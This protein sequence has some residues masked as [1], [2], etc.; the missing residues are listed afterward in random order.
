M[1][2]ARWLSLYIC[3]NRI[4]NRIHHKKTSKNNN[5]KTE[6]S[7]KT[8]FHPKS[9]IFIE[10]GPINIIPSSFCLGLMPLERKQG[11]IDKKEFGQ[12]LTSAFSI[13]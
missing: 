8:D 12:C 1:L 3:Q 10:T 6:I 11:K 5:K 7:G 13:R 9:V 4:F 2:S